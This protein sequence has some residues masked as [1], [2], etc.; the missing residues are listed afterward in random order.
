[1]SGGVSAL[2]S[3]AVLLKRLVA[4]VGSLLPIFGVILRL[5]IWVESS[6]DKDAVIVLATGFEPFVAVLLV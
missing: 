3:A 5:R 2:V 1:M 6:V 4:M